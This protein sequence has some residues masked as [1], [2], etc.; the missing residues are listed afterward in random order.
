MYM[1]IYIGCVNSV[2]FIV[3]HIGAAAATTSPPISGEVAAAAPVSN[4]EYYRV[5]TALYK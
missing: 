4:Y 3:S 1:Y 5:Y 2:V